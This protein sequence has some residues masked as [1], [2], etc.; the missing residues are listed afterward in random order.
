MLTMIENLF[1]TKG[2]NGIDRE[3]QDRYLELK[4]QAMVTIRKY[5]LESLAAGLFAGFI[6]GKVIKR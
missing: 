3:M 5:P 6:I 4:D 1:N 2:G